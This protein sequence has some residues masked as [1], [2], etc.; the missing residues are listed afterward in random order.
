MKIREFFMKMPIFI[1][2]SGIFN[3]NFGTSFSYKTPMLIVF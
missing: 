1:G 2:F 3:G